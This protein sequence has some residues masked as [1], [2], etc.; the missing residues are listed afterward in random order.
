MHACVLCGAVPKRGKKKLE[1]QMFVGAEI[2]PGWSHCSLTPSHLFSPLSAS[3]V[4]PIT[5]VMSLYVPKTM[6]AI[7]ESIV[8][9][10]ISSQWDQAA[11]QSTNSLDFFFCTGMQIQILSGRDCNLFVVFKFFI[12]FGDVLCCACTCCRLTYTRWVLVGR[13][14]GHLREFTKRN[15]FDVC[16]EYKW[17]LCVCCIFLVL[18]VEPVLYR[19]IGLTYTLVQICLANSFSIKGKI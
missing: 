6:P 19:W 2:E 5:G 9:R 17:L 1:L 11:S 15:S 10:K 3:L 14:E 4:V 18:G 16:C 12:V 7:F 13:Y 8:G